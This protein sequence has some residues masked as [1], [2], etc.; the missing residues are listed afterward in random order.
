LVAEFGDS[1]HRQGIAF[2]VT[3]ARGTA[4]SHPVLLTSILRNLVRN[5]IDYTPRGGRVFVASHRCGPEVHIKVR[6]AGAGIRIRASAL[7]TIFD[8]FRHADEWSGSGP[9]HFKARADLLG[10][11][12]EVHSVEGRDSR[13]RSW[14]GPPVMKMSEPSPIWS[15]RSSVRPPAMPAFQLCD[16]SL[17]TAR[18][19]AR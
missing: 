15:A 14:L 9:V 5:A 13:L 17:R 19:A 6:Y 2:R 12:V 4:S 18:S 10:H 16:G 3:T 11:R 8:A 7:A 1:A